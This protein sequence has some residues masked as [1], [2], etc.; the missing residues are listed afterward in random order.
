MANCKKCG[1]SLVGQYC[2][3]CG[4]PATLKRIDKSYIISEISS[5]LNLDKGILYTI[6]QLLLSPGNAV[7]KFISEDRNRL[8]K[9][10]LFIL[11]TSLIYSVL[12]QIL[13]FEDAYVHYNEKQKSTTFVIFKWVQSNYG[14]SNLIM[15]IFIAAWIKLL[16]K[17]YTY[18]FY[19][20][21]ILLCFVMGIGML[22][23]AF[24]GAVQSITQLKVLDY[25]G[26]LFFLY[27]VWAIGQFFNPKKWTSYAKATL[28]YMLGLFTFTVGILL[29]GKLI[30]LLK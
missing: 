25:G 10:I 7:K 24:F 26:M 30:D 17:K 23:L 3:N 14:Y 13:H 5:V 29:I 18:N 6:K 15:G 27:I 1:Q 2:S 11:I 28:A 12:V 21:L 19:E 22:F 4:T 16:F 20:I 9:P 8:V